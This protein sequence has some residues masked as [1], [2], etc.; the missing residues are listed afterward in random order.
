M[1]DKLQFVVDK[2]KFVGL[3][4]PNYLHKDDCSENQVAA[5]ARIHLRDL[6]DQGSVL[7]ILIP[8]LAATDKRE[9]YLRLPFANLLVRPLLLAERKRHK[10][11]ERTADA[12]S[13]R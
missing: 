7:L 5:V 8:D 11:I 6:L 3:P 13:I 12:T 10:V 4:R 1:S 9:E 2:L